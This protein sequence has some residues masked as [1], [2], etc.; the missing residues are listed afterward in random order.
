M[1]RGQKNR[2]SALADGVA[3]GL[4]VYGFSYLGLLPILGLLKPAWKQTFAQVVGEIFRHVLYG[5]TTAASFGFIGGR[6]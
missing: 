1:W 5:I 3:L 6:E 2:G 4:F